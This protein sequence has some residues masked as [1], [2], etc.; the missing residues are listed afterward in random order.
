MVSPPSSAHADSDRARRVA[1]LV[2]TMGWDP[3]R[4]SANHPVFF[5][6]EVEDLESDDPSD[7]LVD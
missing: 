3:D 4:V 2:E 6:P 1:A 7:P 5:E